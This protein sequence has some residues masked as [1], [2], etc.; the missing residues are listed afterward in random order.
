MRPRLHKAVVFLLLVFAAGVPYVRA[1]YFGRNKVQYQK[2]DFRVMKTR[3]FDIYFYL[4]SQETV[5]QAALMAE[6]WYS[7]LSRMF[8]HELKGRQPLVLYS[9][10]P[11][12]QQTTTISGTLGEG[13]GGVTESFKRRVILPYGASLSETDHV[14]GHE[15]V[16]AFQYDIMAQG[17]SD[18]QRGNTDA[19]RIPLWFIEG[20]A[21]YLSIGPYD[22]NTAMWMRDTVRR[23]DI[24]QIEK[25][26]NE[27][28]Y[29]PYRYGHALWAY[30]TGRLGDEIIGKMMK[31]VGRQGSWEATLEA[32]LGGKLKKISADWHKAM[33]DAYKPLYDKTE[34][35]DKIAK[36]LVVGSEESAYNIS[37]SL[38]PDG[39]KMIFLSSRDL[40]SV[41]L[42]LGDAKTGRIIRKIISTA[43]DPH[44]ESLGFIRSAGSWDMKGERFVF[45]S[46]RKG[47]PNL[48][49]I[50][51]DKNKIER[52]IPFPEL[53]EIL[54]PA[55]SPDGRYIVF[56]ALAGGISDIFIYDLETSTV[57]QMTRDSFGDLLPVWSPD[58]KK[59]AF[60]TERFSTNM[61]WMDIGNYE[62]AL[63]DPESARIEKILA[64][65]SGKNINPQWSP[66]SRSL[67]FL[68]DQSG[69]TDLFRIELESG[70]I[71]EVTN[72]YAG[73]SGITDLSP[74]ISVAQIS[75]RLVF[76]GYDK[77]HYSLYAVDSAEILA[78]RP[79]LTQFGSMNLGVLP[80][81]TQPEGTLLGLL[82]NP[83]FGLPGNT[84]FAVS[85]YKP[86]LSLDYVSPPTVAVG[87]DRYGTYGA[88]G[89]AATW[90]DMLGYHSLVTMAQTSNR[91]ID[92]SVAVA[93]QNN[94]HRWNWGAS[95]Q[96]F[97]YPYSYYSVSE[98]EVLGE[99]ALI[100]QESIYRQIVY[101]ASLFTQYPLSQVRRLEFSG[102]YRI[103]DFDWTVYTRAYS[104]YD[105]S[106][107]LYEKTKQPTPDSLHYGYMTASLVY[108]S[109]IFG[110]TSPIL[111][112]SYI[113]QVS[114]T[115]GSPSYYT[116]MADYR[117][118]MIP[119][120]PVTAA[121]RIMHYGRFGK[122]AEDSRMWPLYIGYW[123]I[124]RGYESFSSNF[125][126]NRLYGSKILVANA[127]IRFPLFRV[128]GIG[129]GY[130]G[131]FPIEAYGFYD[132]GLAW[133]AENKAWFLNGGSRKPV[134]SAG[135]GL[136][137]N[138]FGY[139][140]LGV[141][142][143]YPFQ[144]PSKG[145]HFQLSISPGF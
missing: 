111:G 120:K 46:V 107:L 65:P 114:P 135:F 77:G 19:L 13:T 3:H 16:H 100:E 66:D 136:R 51:V 52:E 44:F 139:L 119:F 134:T 67:Y 14:I 109:S 62:L 20:M 31:S 98:G 23:K 128:L 74:A 40:F 21:E 25:M 53:G 22:P 2:F 101:D 28:K 108:D 130:Y 45:G 60:V 126:Y 10:G 105:Y 59:I 15:L 49:I 121:F 57:R 29:F 140:I 18:A 56:S 17:H 55:W 69:K 63:L 116:L 138:L 1:Q 145:W 85:G 54:S 37:P 131:P 142:Y 124:V 36:V 91:L 35:A 82:K 71:F 104:Y 132:W 30:F 4:E 7:R 72:L 80:P 97:S 9:S 50:Q 90:S 115:V 110:A 33:E 6:R 64:F 12:F 117:K 123:D 95:L 61:N 87:V 84:N 106:L 103:L 48:T 43:V 102:G 144:N 26:D 96:R 118:Y 94:R 133:D 27:Y 81:R 24:P 125:D 127:E 113:V 86:K 76:S 129:S 38:N 88:G 83:M 68:S 141:H 112:Q 42:Y 92:T 93:Y 122:D 78:G 5:K 137:T 73:I 8:N 41:D 58:G 89:I 47:R 79:H 143:V 32:S 39:T 99:P 75:G 70:K 11:Q 34:A